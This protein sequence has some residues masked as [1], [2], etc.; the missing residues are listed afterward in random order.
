MLVSLHVLGLLSISLI[1]LVSIYWLPCKQNSGGIELESTKRLQTMSRLLPKQIQVTYKSFESL[2]ADEKIEVIR[3]WKEC[4]P[5]T[6]FN[7][8]NPGGIAIARLQNKIIGYCGYLTSDKLC[9][10]I[11]LNYQNGKHEDYGAK[12]CNDNGI[13]F[14]NLCISESYRNQQYEHNLIKQMMRRLSASY[15]YTWCQ[16]NDNSLQSFY[17]K[18]GFRVQKQTQQAVILER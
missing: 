10:W 13:Y 17:K 7:F 8:Y 16:S 2:T 4:Y 1:I 15:F 9:N 6:V 11:N 18:V 14:Y 5:D 12:S 3:I